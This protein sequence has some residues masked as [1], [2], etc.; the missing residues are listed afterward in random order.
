M[1]VIKTAIKLNIC[2]KKNPFWGPNLSSFSTR[3]QKIIHHCAGRDGRDE[4]IL[5]E[6]QRRR[7]RE[8]ENKENREQ[9][10]CDRDE[11]GNRRN[12]ASHNIIQNM[13][14]LCVCAHKWFGTN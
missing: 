7:L 1:T 13:Q 10:R 4:I 11:D 9:I 8:C 2:F 12:A 5:D 3:Q 14:A 6:I